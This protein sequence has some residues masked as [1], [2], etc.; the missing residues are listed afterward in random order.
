MLVYAI[1]DTS[2]HFA[3]ARSVLV[4]LAERAAPW[5]IP[6][7]CA[8]EFLRVVTHPRVFRRPLEPDRAVQELRNI[9]AAPNLLML[10]ETA[11]HSEV[12][13]AVMAESGAKGNLVHDAHIW[14]L[15]LEHGVSELLSGD[16]DFSRFR[17]LRLRNPFLAEPDERS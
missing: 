14:A 10:S 16:R 9:C 17:G 2:G 8:Y 7:P 5:A 4:D 1:N 13:T 11:R 3:A 15:C 6:W 12:L